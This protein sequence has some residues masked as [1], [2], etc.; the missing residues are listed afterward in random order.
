MTDH[1][2]TLTGAYVLDALD[3]DER[4][5]FT[6][7]LAGCQECTAEVASL[8]ATAVALALGDAV[9]P[10]PGLRA[11]VLADIART[12]QLG[13][14]PVA[15]VTPVPS[16]ATR[17]RSAGSRSRRTWPFAAAAVVLLVVVGGGI[18]IR[19]RQ[20][21]ALADTQAA[22]M[23]IVSAPDAVSHDLALGSTHVVMSPE[24]GAIA[25]MGQ[26]VPMPDADGMVYQV[27]MVHP[28]GSTAAGPTFMPHDGE[29][30]TIVQGDLSDV[31]ELTVTVEP[32]G[33]STAP[34]G[35]MVAQVAL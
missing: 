18:V 8:R 1:L 7:H 3:P 12:A 4:A 23:R 10:P 29:V 16:T 30:T 34:T 13:P 31:M 9:T 25:L 20:A 35:G 11:A 21:D 6:A 19:D 26:D 32:R 28:D 2:H 24:M 15:T 5:A 27:W 17:S 14:D 33:G 22:A